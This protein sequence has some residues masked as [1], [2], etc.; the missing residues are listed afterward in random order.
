MYNTASYAWVCHPDY[1]NNYK[2][3]Y[4]GVCRCTTIFTFRQDGSIDAAACF[5][6]SIAYK[7]TI[8]TGQIGNKSADIDVCTLCKARNVSQLILAYG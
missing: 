1:D 6:L 8:L 7:K 4:D 3:E 5:R 2:H